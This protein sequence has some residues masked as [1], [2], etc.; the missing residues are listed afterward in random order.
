MLYDLQNG[1]SNWFATSPADFVMLA[2]C[3]LNFYAYLF[4][5]RVL[6][7]SRELCYLFLSSLNDHKYHLKPSLNPTRISILA[8]PRLF[9]QSQDRSEIGS[10]CHVLATTNH[11]S[12]SML[13][14]RIHLLFYLNQREPPKTDKRW[15][16]A[17]TASEKMVDISKDY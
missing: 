3:R 2:C 7:M 14:L 10:N 6:S 12:C 15:R 11:M 16:T 5:I 4:I 13:D 17:P 8:G 9:N 1:Y